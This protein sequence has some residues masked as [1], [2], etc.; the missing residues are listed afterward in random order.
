LLVDA[1]QFVNLA[2]N[3]YHNCPPNITQVGDACEDSAKDMMDQV[4]D[5]VQMLVNGTVDPTKILEDAE[6]AYADLQ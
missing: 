6:K 1:E 2:E 5:V 3:I 4:F